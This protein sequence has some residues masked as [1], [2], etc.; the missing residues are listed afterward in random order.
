MMSMPFLLLGSFSGYMY[1]AVRK[2]RR[3][4]AAKQQAAM[5]ESNSLDSRGAVRERETVEV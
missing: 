5:T 1:L 3:E 4:L 2:A